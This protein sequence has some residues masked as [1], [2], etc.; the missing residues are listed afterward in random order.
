[1]GAEAVRVKSLFF[2]VK[3][4]RDQLDPA[5][6]RALS[7]FGAFV[8]RRAKSSLKYKDGPA[9]PGQPPHVHRTT[10]FTAKK[11]KR[12]KKGKPPK[13]VSPLREL[14]FFSYDPRNKSVVIGPAI[15]GPKS[16]APETLEEG[17]TASRDG[18][19]VTIAPRPTMRP[20]FRI[21]LDKVGGDFR[22]II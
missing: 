13:P 15:G 8:R 10:V 17:G 11:G 3:A 2:T 22:A 6:R 20:A 19:T 14:L 16:G 7:K 1:M 5:V 18:K 21:E 12:P 9:P 4:V